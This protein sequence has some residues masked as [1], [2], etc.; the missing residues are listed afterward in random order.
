M[1]IANIQRNGLDYILTDL[2]PLE[3]SEMFTFQHFYDYLLGN[4]KIIKE[5]ISSITKIKNE[6]NRSIK[7]FKGPKWTSM[8]L[9][10]TIRKTNDSVRELNVVQPIAALQ[11]Y[12][13][14]TI[15]QKELISL[16]NKKSIFSLRYHHKA[17]N[18]YYKA[19]KKSITT[20]FN[21]T[22][23]KLSR[24]VIEQTGMFFDLKPYKSISEFT[25]SDHWFDLNLRFNYYAKID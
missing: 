23:K 16:L 6:V 9:K 7:M 1:G 8:P 2:L 19:K 5:Q 3:L 20:Y 25:S 13:F 15:Y 21:T 24:G 11:L 4:E 12:Y 22:A 17:S 10:Y 18:L 14:V